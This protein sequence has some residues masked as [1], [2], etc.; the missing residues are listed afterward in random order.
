MFDRDGTVELNADISGYA[1]SMTQAINLSQQYADSVSGVLGAAVKVQGAMVGLISKTTGMAGANRVGT[2]VAAAYEQQLSGIASTAAVT[3]QNFGDLSKT[4]MKLARDL[5]VGMA[6]AVAQVTALQKSGVTTTA[7]VGALAKEF[8]NLQGATGEFNPDMGAQMLQLSRTMGNGTSQIGKLDDS[9]VTVTKNFGASA[10]ATIG[11]AKAIAPIATTVG[12]SQT[13]V[14]GLSTAFARLGDDGLSAGTAVNKVLIDMDKSIRTG[15][16]EIRQYAS[17]LNM[18]TDSLG[19]MFKSDPTAVLLRFTDAIRK[20]GAGAIRTLDQLGLDGVRTVNAVTSL[21]RQGD[22]GKVIDT[23]TAAYGDGSTAKGAAAAFGGVNDQL[24]RFN[25]TMQQTV[26]DSGAP[27]LA[28]MS[29]ALGAANSLAEILK[30]FTGSSFGQG[31]ATVGAVATVGG[32]LAV[33]AISGLST[34]ALATRGLAAMRNSGFAANYR[35]GAA[36]VTG[37]EAMGTA[38]GRLGAW[39]ATSFGAPPP[40]ISAR[41]IVDTGVTGVR[42]T[43]RGLLNWGAVGLSTVSN[44]FRTTRGGAAVTTSAGRTLREE[45]AAARAGPL[46]P[47]AVPVPGPGYRVFTGSATGPPTI[48]YQPATGTRV[49]TGSVT[50]PPTIGYQAF[51]RA[52]TTEAATGFRGVTDAVRKFATTIT[53][54]EGSVRTFGRSMVGVVT[55]AASYAGSGAKAVGTGL[56]GLLGISAPMLGLAAVAGAGYAFYKGDQGTKQAINQNNATM[57]SSIYSAYNDFAAKIGGASKGLVGFAAVVQQSTQSLAKQVTTQAQAATLTDAQIKQAQ[58]SDY[59]PGMT[60]SG[61]VTKATAKDIATQIVMLLGNSPLPS[62]RVQTLQDVVH[63][64][65]PKM[66]A[67]VAAIVDKVYGAGGTGTASLGYGP[68]IS[69]I[70]TLQK[71]QRFGSLTTSDAAANTA[72]VMGQSA[73]DKVASVRAASG[74]AAGNAATLVEARQMYNDAAAATKKGTLAPGSKDAALIEGQIAKLLGYDDPGTIGMGGGTSF[75]K[76]QFDWKNNPLVSRFTGKPEAPT[77]DD[78]MAGV[79]KRPNAAS[80][81]FPTQYTDLAGTGFNFDSPNY[82]GMGAKNVGQTTA[83]AGARSFQ[84]ITEGGGKATAAL[85]ELNDAARKYG[86]TTDKLT[87]AQTKGVSALG[88]AFGAL[89]GYSGMTPLPDQPRAMA[90]AGTALA[91]TLIKTNATPEMARLDLAGLLEAIPSGDVRRGGVEAAQGQLQLASVLPTAAR[92]SGAGS[93]AAMAAGVA[94]ATGPVPIDPAAK[95]VVDAAKTDAVTAVQSRFEMAKQ[96]IMASRANDL[97]LARQDEDAAKSK[98]RAQRDFNLQQTYATVDYNKQVLYANVDYQRQLAWTEADAAKTR[99]R[100]QRDFNRQELFATEDFNKQQLRQAADHTLA[101]QRSAVEAARTTYDPF[102]RIQATRVWDGAG[103]VSNMAQQ[104]AVLDTQRANLDTLH[105]GGL[106]QDAIDTLGLSESANAQQL[107][108]LTSDAATD[109]KLIKTINDEIAARIKSASAITQS[110]DSPTFRQT[111]QDYAKSVARQDE[112]FATTMKRSKAT[113]TISLQDLDKDVATAK[114]RTEISFNT[115][116]ARQDEAFKLSMTRAN[117]GLTTSLTDMATDLGTARTRAMKDL[118]LFGDEAGNGFVDVQKKFLDSVA[119][120]PAGAKSTM[121]ASLKTLLAQ[122]RSEFGSYFNGSAAIFGFKIAPLGAANDGSAGGYSQFNP[123]LAKGTGGSGISYPEIEAAAAGSGIPFSPPSDAQVMGGVHAAGSYHAKGEAVDFS[124]ST[125]NMNKLAAY[126]QDNYGGTLRELI[127]SPN[128]YIKD[129]R[130]VPGSFYGSAVVAQHYNHVHVAG[131]P[132][133]TGGGGGSGS[134]TGSPTSTPN[135]S[136][137]S[138]NRKIGA[139]MAASA[140]WTGSQWTALERL[141]TNESG[142]NNFAQ[143]PSST[144][145]GIAQFL[146]STWAGYGTKTSDPAGQISAGLHYI[147]DRYGNPVNALNFWNAKSP[148]WY[149]EGGVFPAGPRVI[150]V[151]EAGPEAA[152]PLNSRGVGVLAAAMVRYMTSENAAKI[153]SVAYATPITGS[154]AA[155]THS[156]DQRNQF[157]GQVNVVS[158]DPNE[159][160][161]KLRARSRQQALITG[162]R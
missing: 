44:D 118:S 115:T 143:N 123:P 52:A 8:I 140:G 99:M 77:F 66:G 63:Q 144:A 62:D 127:H 138:G 156:Y 26:A 146:N 106:S 70:T 160:A 149:A 128:F 91:G 60:I 145:Y 137:L 54:A 75:A 97:A 19:A 73:A 158:T 139:N 76:Y 69:S 150:G 133:F 124:S 147:K 29:K 61:D 14:M 45:I 56:G 126:F 101:L 12:M 30:K 15:S 153:K 74:D 53:G 9:L 84:V 134:G 161:R 57:D 64:T 102:N 86:V 32:V 148:H 55:S 78:F 40:G 155:I 108:R 34:A 117:K 129:G 68:A 141:W 71:Q 39:R 25:E 82:A 67:D 135:T 113:F 41:G 38:G 35:A 47:A 48:G 90:N 125:A 27:F 37:A 65:S 95:A 18:T 33:K 85:F 110:K 88:L 157:S 49:F 114:S 79:K 5:P 43:G 31:L 94:A 121:S 107:A 7:T 111:E 162:R 100:A 36:E 92:S 22:L 59:K 28:F 109:P 24:T 87:T 120:L 80:I 116:M 6:G 122:M 103:L 13:Q 132:G 51:P 136:G 151:G 159:M 16:P 10:S 42:A 72:G 21:S 23:A 46:T 119:K 152:I 17:L 154:T 130:K 105:K 4:T 89:I 142:W 112:D 50:G 1:T 20:Q 104:R 2:S 131:L 83:E 3:G 58:R 81:N 93:E 96:F 98:F 11:F